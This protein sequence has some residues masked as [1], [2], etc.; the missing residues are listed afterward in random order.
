MGKPR[1][2]PPLVTSDRF[3][4]ALAREQ[5]RV[6]VGADAE[7]QAVDFVESTEA[8]DLDLGGL[9]VRVLTA[10]ATLTDS[11]RELW[12][13]FVVADGRA[14]VALSVRAVERQPFETPVA[15]AATTESKGRYLAKMRG[16][17]AGLDP[18]SGRGAAL[19]ERRHPTQDLSN[20]LRMVLQTFGPAKGRYL[21]HAAC[22][23]IDS[24]VVLLVGQAQAGKSTAARLAAPRPVLS[25]DAVLLAT[26]PEGRVVAAT[27]GFWG[28]EGS[29]GLEITRRPGTHPVAAFVTL[30]K[31][32]RNR[33]RPPRPA[34]RGAR[35]VVRSAAHRA[36]RRRPQ[37][38]P[39][40]HGGGVDGGADLRARVHARRRLVLGADRGRGLAR[41]TVGLGPC[42]TNLNAPQAPAAHARNGPFTPL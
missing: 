40:V 41:S 1:Y 17:L 37:P 16:V 11:L 19:V 14:D 8:L 13:P 31:A 36:R 28:R 21:L 20:L 22:V 6:A 27:I 5:D 34:A 32:S 26:A 9:G 24:G 12:G 39:Q 3:P 30:K 35:A 38:R 33:L 2:V 15:F 18:A 29:D 4:L 7:W 10:D 42:P 25:D 23:A